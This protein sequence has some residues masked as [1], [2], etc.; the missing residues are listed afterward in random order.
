[1]SE[2]VPAV[3]AVVRVLVMEIVTEAA[4][5][6]QEAVP[7][8]VAGVRAVRER[9][10]EA[11]PVV[12]ETVPAAA[13][14]AVRQA[15]PEP[16]PIPAQAVRETAPAVARQTVPGSAITPAPEKVRR[17]L[18]RIWE[19]TSLLDILSRRWTILS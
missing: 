15:A 5:G 1:M 12:R 9:A 16:V 11:A 4:A 2:G 6:V 14:T 17:R 3:R 18:S 8:L 10:A 19:K 13:K 7:V